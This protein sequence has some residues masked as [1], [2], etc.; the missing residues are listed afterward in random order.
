[1]NQ[2]M[3]MLRLVP[4]AC[5]S[6]AI[7][8]LSTLFEMM[9]RAPGFNNAEVLRSMNEPGL[10]LVLHTWDGIDDWHTFQTSDTK[11]AFSSSRPAFLYN[12]EPCGMNWLLKAGEAGEG[13]YLHRQ[14][15]RD[16]LLPDTGPEVISSQ[17]FSYQDYE[18]SLEGAMLR[19]TRTNALP[20]QSLPVGGG[21]LADDVF[22]S[23]HRHSVV[24]SRS[25]EFAG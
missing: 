6:D 13:A 16:S 10:L 17:T 25:F 3:E 1:M 7:A 9:S 11:I 8:R 24:P 22:E 12:F 2:V 5:E 20:A 14:L 21:V 4:G 18:P 15:I 23:V 19:L